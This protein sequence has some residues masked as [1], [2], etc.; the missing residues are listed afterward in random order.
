MQR[1]SRSDD[2]V[3]ADSRLRSGAGAG[4]GLSVDRRFRDLPDAGV[5]SSWV[6]H[7]GA[8]KGTRFVGPP[9]LHFAPQAR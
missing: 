1:A 6:E 3:A 9:G 7:V 8:A 2:S 5:D 4:A